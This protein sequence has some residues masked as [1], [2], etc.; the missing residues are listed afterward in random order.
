VSGEEKALPPTPE[1]HWGLRNDLEK[2]YTVRCGNPS[3]SLGQ[4]LEAWLWHFETVCVAVYRLGQYSR[5]L[6]DRSKLLGAIPFALY[7]LG[8]FLCRLLLHVEISNKA[9]IGPGLHLG[10]PFTILIGPTTIG[11]N[12][13]V[14]HNVTIGLGLGEGGR[15]LPSIG[16]DVWIGPGST[17][18]GPIRVG[19]GAVIAAGSVVSRDVP[20]RAL[21]AG[22]PA[23]VVLANYDSAPLLLYAMR[24]GA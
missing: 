4:R 8:S 15:G 6:V 3:P 21:V 1:R 17:L 20:P 22:N 2:V 9:R 10:H 24:P 16:N 23:R 19:D 14:T 7:V 13:S 11:Y 5:A 18:T 12:C